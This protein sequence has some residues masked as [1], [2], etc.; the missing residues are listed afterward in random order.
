MGDVTSRV[1]YRGHEK[2]LGSKN[3]GGGHL[4]LMD[5]GGE[6]RLLLISGEELSGLQGLWTLNALLWDGS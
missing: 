4:F 2:Y 5:E 6:Q 1:P 3:E